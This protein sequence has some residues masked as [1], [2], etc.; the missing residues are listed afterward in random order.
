MQ[1]AVRKVL[2]T[3]FLVLLFVATLAQGAESK[4]AILKIDGIT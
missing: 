1:R 3:S 2:V 4:T